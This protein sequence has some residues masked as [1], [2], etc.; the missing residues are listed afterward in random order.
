MGI[1]G[2]LKPGRARGEKTH[3]GPGLSVG[4]SNSR[5][6]DRRFSRG[7][8]S[9]YHLRTEGV[10]GLGIQLAENV[11]DRAA[12]VLNTNRAPGRGANR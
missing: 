9:P 5:P 4:R 7:N 12:C 2:G 8:G 3:P 6:L 11:L 10:F 1:G